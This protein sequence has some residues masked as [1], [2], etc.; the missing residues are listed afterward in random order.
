VPAAGQGDPAGGVRQLVAAAG[1]PGQQHAVPRAN[2]TL[3]GTVIA[4]PVLELSLLPARSVSRKPGA[5]VTQAGS[6]NRDLAVSD[7]DERP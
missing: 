1:D 5:A 4:P 6:Q 2:A 3:T 7:R